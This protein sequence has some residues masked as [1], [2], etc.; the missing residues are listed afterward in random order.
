MALAIIGSQCP[1]NCFEHRLPIRVLT[2]CRSKLPKQDCPHYRW[3]QGKQGI[4]VAWRG[5]SYQL[6]QLPSQVGHLRRTVGT[7]RHCRRAIDSSR[8]LGPAGDFRT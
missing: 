1:D 6:D 5:A 7:T 8:S 2:E 3:T 4:S